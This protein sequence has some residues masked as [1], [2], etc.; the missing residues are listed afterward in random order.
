MCDMDRLIRFAPSATCFS[1]KIRANLSGPCAANTSTFGSFGWYSFYFSHHITT[2][3]EEWSCVRL[4]KTPI[5]SDVCARTAGRASFQTKT[6]YTNN[7]AH[8]CV[9]C[10]QCRVNA[11]HGNLWGHWE[12]S[13]SS[14]ESMNANRKENRERL[15]RALK[16]HEKW[17][18]QFRF[19]LNKCPPSMVWLCGR[20]ST[21]SSRASSGIS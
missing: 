20:A 19:R 17:D 10:S 14:T 2:E 8:R 6:S 1:S 16:S 3:K 13:T 11:P 21:R 12:V 5:S 15:L 7:G 18:D 4:K 9:S